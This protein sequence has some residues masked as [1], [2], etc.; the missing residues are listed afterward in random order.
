MQYT[1]LIIDDEFLAV[2]LLENYVKRIENL[3]LIGKFTKSK[4]AFSF[5]EKERTDI[6]LLDVQMPQMNGIELL[7]YL[8]NKPCTVLTTA[9]PQFAVQAYEMDVMDYLVKPFSFDRFQKAIQKCTDWIDLNQKS[10]QKN[11]KENRFMTIKA[12]YQTISIYFDEISYIEGFGEYVKIITEKQKYLSLAALKDLV[13]E[14]PE[15]EFIRIHKSYI[16][17]IQKVRAFSSTTL[18]LTGGEILPIGR[19]YKDAVMQQLENR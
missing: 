9:N 1:A 18:T 13:Q 17:A 16:V 7:S 10:N 14:L 3:T 6:L 12:D 15:S 11:Q 4:E 8:P 19:T 2:K 5:L